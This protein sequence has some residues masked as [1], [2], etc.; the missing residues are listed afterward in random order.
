MYH[1]LV[2]GI[3]FDLSLE[4]LRADGHLLVGVYGEVL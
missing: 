3:L 2:S 4:V 1:T